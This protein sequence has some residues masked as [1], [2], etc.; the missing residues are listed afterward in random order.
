MDNLR[1]KARILSVE[2]ATQYGIH[3]DSIIVSFEFDDRARKED[4]GSPFLSEEN[5]LLWR[6]L[7]LCVVLDERVPA[8]D[9]RYT[10]F[11]QYKSK[12]EG[13]DVYIA[14]DGREVFA[15]GKDPKNMFFP[16][17]Y[18][19]WDLPEGGEKKGDPKA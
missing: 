14:F 16:H 2:T 7:V 15:I 13:E 3:A 9:G 18:G 4:F 17:E 10:I 6:R 8:N 5:I 1:I 19:L 11:E 12:V